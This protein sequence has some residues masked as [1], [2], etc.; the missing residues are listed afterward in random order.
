MSASDNLIHRRTIQPSTI[1]TESS[2]LREHSCHTMHAGIIT[3]F[4]LCD[5]Y[6]LAST[7]VLKE[8]MLELERKTAT[9]GDIRSSHLHLSFSAL[10]TCKSHS[11]NLIF[12]FSFIAPFRSPINHFISHSVFCLFCLNFLSPAHC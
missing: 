8:E 9:S 11:C 7:H 3:P 1:Y 12:W 2:L 5:L 4:S 10:I 6:V